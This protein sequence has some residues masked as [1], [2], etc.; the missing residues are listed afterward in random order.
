MRP[1]ALAA[2]STD[3]NLEAFVQDFLA[4]F[5]AVVGFVWVAPVTNKELQLLERL[6]SAILQ[7]QAAVFSKEL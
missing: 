3:S 2:G 5:R 7:G 6:V 4:S 1:A